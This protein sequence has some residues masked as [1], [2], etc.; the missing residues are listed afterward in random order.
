MP[1]VSK[2]SGL[3]E[4]AA[5]YPAQL[6]AHFD[7]SFITSFDLFEEYVARL[8]LGLFR[9]VGAGHGSPPVQLVGK[10]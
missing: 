2:R 8:T 5:L 1:I 7:D 10:L 3:D 4:R 9:S 6:L